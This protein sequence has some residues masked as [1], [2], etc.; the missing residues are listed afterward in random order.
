MQIL[1]LYQTVASS[2]IS[3][4]ALAVSPTPY[5]RLS[6]EMLKP[7]CTHMRLSRLYQQML[8]SSIHSYTTTDRTWRQT[9]LQ[10]Y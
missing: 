4:K 6:L 3:C 2:I 7:S 5:K 1:T 10:V 9:I 8:S